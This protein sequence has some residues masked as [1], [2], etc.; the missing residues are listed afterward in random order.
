MLQLFRRDRRETE[1][2]GEA[3]ERLAAEWLRREK[4]FRILARNWRARRD[5]RLELDI[6]ARDGE[7]L[8]FVEVK[9]RAPEALVPGYHAA[10]TPAKKRSVRRAAKAYVASLAERP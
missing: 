5:R 7:A 6:V 9:T 4:G 2:T 1:D 3:G 8:V 10:V